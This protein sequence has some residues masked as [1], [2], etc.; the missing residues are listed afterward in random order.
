MDAK[1]LVKD[2][3]GRIARGDAGG[4]CGDEPSTLLERYASRPAELAQMIG[5]SEEDVASVPEGAN[6][7]LGCGN[8]VALASLRPGEVVL[9]LGCGGGFDCF[10][11][12]GRVGPTGRVIGVD[13]TE[14]M[15]AKARANAARGG[16]EN[17]EF[18]LG[19]IESL[20]VDDGSVDVVISNCVLNLVP[21]KPRAF[22]EIHR[23]LKPG[24]RAAISDMVLNG[25]LP[26]GL[27]VPEAYTGCIAGAISRDEYLRLLGE[28]GL[29]NVR[30]VGET[31]AR[32]LLA[33]CPDPVA[34]SCCG[35]EVSLAD[36]P[37]GLVQSLQIEAGRP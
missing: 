36:L 34:A 6:L 25:P 19:E 2:A 28:A 11:A 32:S 3:Y 35:S 26:E 18:R 31:D 4:C 29:T 30:V 23:V 14:D 7:G 10:L 21:D 27:N 24:G 12:A 22:A 8:P 13:M 17:V 5:Y 20:P 9:D 15:V 1:R 16:Y 33:C 37:E